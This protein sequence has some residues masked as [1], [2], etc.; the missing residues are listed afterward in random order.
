[1]GSTRRCGGDSSIGGK[2]TNGSIRVREAT[3]RSSQRTKRSG[4][5]GGGLHRCQAP[6]RRDIFLPRT[7]IWDPLAASAVHI[8]HL[9][10]PLLKRE[11]LLARAR[12]LLLPLLL[13]CLLRPAQAQ[14]HRNR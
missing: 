12:H 5:R 4:E 8:Q 10:T 7:G 6:I 2:E 1:M 3:E 14:R 11:L 9:V 13:L